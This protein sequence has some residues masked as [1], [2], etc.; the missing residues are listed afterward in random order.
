MDGV[1][2][3]AVHVGRSH[4]GEAETPGDGRVEDVLAGGWSG[5]AQA[6]IRV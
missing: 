2:P 3:G 4:P 5:S 1:L 6:A